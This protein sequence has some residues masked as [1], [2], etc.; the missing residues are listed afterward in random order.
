MT[1]PVHIDHR[2][3][4]DGH[5]SGAGKAALVGVN[6]V[7]AGDRGK[8]NHLGAHSI[9]GVHG[10]EIKQPYGMIEA[11]TAKDLHRSIA[12]V[13]LHHLAPHH[14]GKIVVLHQKSPVPRGLRLSEHL[15]GV[16][17]P[18][19]HRGSGVDMDVNHTL[20]QRTLV[21]SILPK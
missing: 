3:L 2:R 19:G 7:F 16:Q 4:G 5:L 8:I 12:Q 21:H 11:Q 18:A 20:Q 15:G 9:G 13:L 1:P 10:V 6:V 17:L 14:T